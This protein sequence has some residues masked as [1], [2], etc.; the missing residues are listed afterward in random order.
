MKPLILIT[1]LIA[2]TSVNALAADIAAGK[3]K[4]A[5]CIACHG[6]NGKAAIPTYPNL[7]GQHPQYLVDA[8]KQYRDGGRNNPIMV[9]MAKALT[10]ED[11]K[12]VAA[13]FASFK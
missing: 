2:L 10:D 13:Y 12:N 3:E 7:A 6:A 5:V 9:P 1:A 4:A 8:L 11:M